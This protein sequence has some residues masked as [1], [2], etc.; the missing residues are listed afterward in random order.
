MPRRAPRCFRR[1]RTPGLPRRCTRGVARPSLEH[2][3]RSLDEP[4]RTS[5][6]AFVEGP[7]RCVAIECKFAEREFGVCSRPKLQPGDTTFA[8]QYC[9]GGYRV[10]RGRSER[11]ALTEIGVG[12]WKYL[13]RLFDWNAV[14]DLSPCPF[15][16]VYQLAR[17]ALAVTVTAEGSTQTPDTF[18]SYMTHEIQSSQAAAGRGGNMTR[19]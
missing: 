17:N 3:V 9:D 6:D 18:W 4:R 13:P 2:E 15:S 12:Y 8:K 10:Q 1:L 5:V 16:A 11:C 14:R 7:S 19:R